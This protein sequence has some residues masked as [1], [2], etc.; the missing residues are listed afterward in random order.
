MEYTTSSGLVVH[1][2]RLRAFPRD[3]DPNSNEA[4]GSVGPNVPAGYGDEHVMWDECGVA[5]PMVQAWQGWPVEWA[6]PT[7]GSMAGLGE[8]TRRVSTVFAAISKQAQIISTMPPYRTR[9][10]KVTSQLAWMRN[11]EPQAY[12]DWIEAFEQIVF[13]YLGC[14]EVF[15]WATSR[16]K[17]SGKIASWVML[18]PAWVTVD[19]VPGSANLRRFTLGGEDITDDVLHIRYAS[20]PGD[21]RGHG[22]L[23]AAARAMFGAAAL[24]QYQADLAARG[25]IPWGV[26]TVPGRLTAEQANDARN[27]YVTAR[28]GARGAPAVFSGGATLSPLNVSP[29][30][31]AL[32]EL[33]QF[34]EARLAVLLGVP[35]FLLALPSGAD[36]LTYQ[37]VEGIYDYHWRS[38][39]RTMAAKLTS[40]IGRWI[41]P[42]GEELELNR[43]EYTR[44]A[45]Q[46]RMAG[47]ASLHGIVEVGPDGVERRAI[48]IDEIRAA[49][50]LDAD[51]QVDAASS[52]SLAVPA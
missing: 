19:F 10:G 17:D 50:R 32:L 9:N 1:D 29:K 4:V 44:P 13:S 49:E 3:V 30:D 8:I 26:I 46:D 41:L 15:L 20:W 45:F 25:G 21:A 36:S 31:M 7:W 52:S 12:N 23:E 14:G 2:S 48:T 22:P 34:D 37:T 42:P 18:N 6:T 11:P 35:P 39:L 33:R 5:P 28:L 27:Q 16:F 24:E 40:A 38:S 43:D 47:Y 51:D